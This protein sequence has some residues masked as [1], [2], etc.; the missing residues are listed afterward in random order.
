MDAELNVLPEIAA[1]FDPLKNTLDGNLNDSRWKH[2]DK[3]L[4]KFTRRAVMNPHKSTQAQRPVFDEVDF[5]TIWTP[6]SQLTVID[7]PVKDGFYLKRFGKR[8]EDW[9]AGI[10]VAMNGTPLDAFP[11]LFNKIGLVAELKA[12][13]IMTVEQLANLPD[14]PMHGIMGGY[15]LRAKAQEWLNTTAGEAD[16]A[17]KEALKK[18][19]AD[20]QAQMATLLTAKQA[21]KAATKE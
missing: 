19:L 12:M 9:K 3:L 8:Y 16:K 14:G 6:G 13:H 18:Q 20:L 4:V 2:D 7:T 11:F 17:E 15:E 10:D 21:P 5:I 1:E